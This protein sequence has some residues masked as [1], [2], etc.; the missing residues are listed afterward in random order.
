MSNTARGS[1]TRIAFEE[2]LA[3]T[4]LLDTQPVVS[5]RF[6]QMSTLG[7]VDR[8]EQL[9]C[10]AY[11]M[12]QES[13]NHIP[14]TLERALQRSLKNGRVTLAMVGR[15]PVCT[16]VV[17]SSQASRVHW[18]V[19]ED[20]VTHVVRVVD[21]NSMHGTSVNLDCGGEDEDISTEIFL[22]LDNPDVC[23]SSF[24]LRPKTIDVHFG[25]LRMSLKVH[26]S[27]KKRQD[28]FVAAKKATRHGLVA[29]LIMM[30]KGKAK[31]DDGETWDIPR[32][33]RDL[34]GARPGGVLSVALS[35][36]LGCEWEN[37]SLEYN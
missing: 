28:D 30:L 5:M 20:A 16:L 24:H 6:S 35:D 7:W 26:R 29:F 27:V 18:A 36:F 23:V 33:Y 1:E 2:G 12:S 4:S 13:L 22:N 21:L 10:G 37:L 31:D 25:D 32:R 34:A 15:S 14:K 11:S 8:R 19:Y 3:H 17:E 9:F